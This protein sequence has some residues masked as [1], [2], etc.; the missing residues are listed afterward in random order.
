MAKSKKQK[1]LDKELSEALSY[2]TDDNTII[3]PDGA[4][5]YVQGI[6]DG[7]YFNVNKIKSLIKMG[8]DVNTCGEFGITPL[9]MATMTDDTPFAKSLIKAGAD[10]EAYDYTEHPL[11]FTIQNNNTTLTKLLIKA[12]IDVDANYDGEWTPLYWEHRS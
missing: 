8:A 12:G 2:K 4:Y 3:K 11:Y 7:F 9:Q 10:V 1:E 5:V 6:C